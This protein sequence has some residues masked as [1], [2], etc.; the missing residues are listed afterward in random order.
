MRGGLGC[1]VRWFALRREKLKQRRKI[2]AE[3]QRAQRKAKDLHREHRE[4]PENTEKDNCEFKSRG[5]RAGGTPA[6][7]TATARGRLGALAGNLV[8]GFG[9]WAWGRWDAGWQ[10]RGVERNN[11][12]DNVGDHYWFEVDEDAVG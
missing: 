4:K 6:L 12:D 8:A 10:D 9:G 3:A 5:N 7:R 2:T 1:S 11:R